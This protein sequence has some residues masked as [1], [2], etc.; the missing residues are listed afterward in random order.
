M[1]ICAHLRVIESRLNSQL[2]PGQSLLAVYF[3]NEIQYYPLTDLKREGV[4]K[5]GIRGKEAT[6]TH[7]NSPPFSAGIPGS[8]L[9]LIVNKSN[10]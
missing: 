3:E 10:D 2:S 5:N 8:R 4:G 1:S 7:A 6:V 9:D